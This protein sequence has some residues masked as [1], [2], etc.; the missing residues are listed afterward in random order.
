MHVFVRKPPFDKTTA[1]IRGCL[2]ENG[3]FE[4]DGPEAQADLLMAL[5]RYDGVARA[6]EKTETAAHRDAVTGTN[7]DLAEAIGLLD[8]GQDAH[9]TSNNLPSLKFLATLVNRDVDRRE[10]EEVAAGYTRAK[11]RELKG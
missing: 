7:S 5:F 8:P 3:R 9:W 6:S 4:F 10:V 2:F 11:A 1:T